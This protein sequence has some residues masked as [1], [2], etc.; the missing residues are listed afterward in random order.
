VADL[1]DRPAIKSVLQQVEPNYI[2][3]L[4]AL[5]RNATLAELL[6]VNVTGTENLLAAI[7]EVQPEAQVLVAGSA[8]EYG[9]VR[10]EDLPISESCPLRPLS[11]YGLSKVAQSL[12][13]GQFWLRH[14]VA[15]RRVRTFNLTG[16]GEP[17]TQVASAM[18]RQIVEIE[19][20]L[21]APQMEVGNLDTVRDFIDIRDAVRAYWRV[22]CQGQPG[23]VYNVCAGEGVQIRA[24]L[25]ALLGQTSSQIAII[26]AKTRFS[27]WDVP[28]QVGSSDKLSN[29]GK[30]ERSFVL[31]ESL[32]A[33]MDEWRGSISDATK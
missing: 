29:L 4:A 22:I 11:P 2:F 13:A 6:E 27:P 5:I 31:Q 3:H 21:R 1:L 14:R 17:Q 16:P 32:S 28:L 10:E 23:D 19:A 18:A 12:L 25:H 33:L 7:R 26:Q 30:F 20:G 9:L 8:A 15:V 24:L